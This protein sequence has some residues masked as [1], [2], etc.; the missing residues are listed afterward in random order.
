MDVYR[1]HPNLKSGRRLSTELKHAT[2]AECARMLTEQYVKGLFRERFTR[3]LD[4]YILTNGPY[5]ANAETRDEWEAGLDDQIENILQ[6]FSSCFSAS[7]LGVVC[8]DARIWEAGNLETTLDVLALDAWRVM[9]HTI[10]SGPIRDRDVV[11]LTPA[12]IASMLGFRD[13][14]DETAALPA[15]PS[16]PDDLSRFFMPAPSYEE[17]LSKLRAW[18]VKTPGGSLIAHLDNV[19]DT[20]PGLSESSARILGLTGLEVQ[21]LQNSGLGVN[22]ICFGVSGAKEAIKPVENPM[23]DVNALL[24]LPPIPAP[25]AAIPALPGLPALPP[26]PAAAPALPGLPS[27][28]PLPAPASPVTASLPNPPA[29]PEPVR[30]TRKTKASA[31]PAAGTLSKEAV[32]AFKSNIAGTDETIANALGLSRQSYNNYAAGRA[33]F[34][35]SA[36]QR[37]TMI[38]MVDA[39]IKALHDVRALLLS[40]A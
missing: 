34:I 28:P 23:N 31:T 21:F 16:T 5:G 35:P 17:I 4:Q 7:V 15:V 25:A 6:D 12:R 22:D 1:N 36:D 2:F 30:K 19:M 40:V 37:N 10:S 13:G 18:T 20:D 24:G 33:P 14:T 29:I 9:T 8:V 39:Q 3:M 26:L 32:M 27:L 11:Q 38:A